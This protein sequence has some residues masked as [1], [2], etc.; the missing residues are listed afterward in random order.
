[1]LVELLP[2]RDGIRVRIRQV[3]VGHLKNGRVHYRPGGPAEGPLGDGTTS[4]VTMCACGRPY[5]VSGAELAAAARAGKPLS[6]APMR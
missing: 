2:S 4:Y 3:A 1:M 6:A 5:M